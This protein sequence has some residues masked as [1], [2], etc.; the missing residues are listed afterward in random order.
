MG[1][2]R[3]AV[4][5]P[6][7]AL[8]LLGVIVVWLLPD[9]APV[10]GFAGLTIGTAVV[11]VLLYTRSSPLAERE[12]TAWR[13]VGLG[14]ALF[15]VGVGVVGVLTE[16]GITLP[17][18]GPIDA[19]FLGAYAAIIGGLYRLIRLEAG[20]REW[21]LTIVDALVAAIALAALV[22]DAF[23]H[24]LIK[25]FGEARWWEAAIA[26]TYPVM[27][28]AVVVGLM[29]LVMRRSAYHFDLRL[30][31]FALGGVAQVLAD[32]IFLNR[33]VGE[34]FTP[35]EPAWAVNL[36]AL[37]FMTGTAAIVD[38]VPRKR[39]FPEAPTPVWAL[40]WPYLLAVSLVI[41]HFRN[42]R[43]L[44]PDVDSVVL[45]DAVILIGVVIL[46]RQLYM[47]YRDRHRVD[48]KRAELVASVSH[49]LRTPLTAM[50]GFLAI[51]EQHPDEFPPEAQQE[52]IAESADQARHMS[53]LV[54]D[55]LMLAGGE[56]RRMALELN[57]VWAMAVVN[58]V[59]H[60]TDTGAMVVDKDLD[61]EVR[62]RLDPDRVRQA[63]S[64]LVTNALRYG[65]NR[66]LIVARVDGEDL[67]LEVHD[68][69]EG[70]PTRF[71]S[72]IWEHF[73]RGAHRLDSTTPGLGIGLSIVR[74]VA[75]SHGGK[76]GYRRSERL[77]GACF[78][79]T[80]PGCVTSEPSV[81]VTVG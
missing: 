45:L 28:I 81:P 54:A 80:I 20:G 31:L 15:G 59:I 71:E 50:V 5:G 30:V 43:A 68:D 58:S 3:W 73:E 14:V 25:T 49:E 2:M 61:A 36:I 41:V 78:T 51:L 44:G 19:F 27:D 4:P 60:Q 75:E 64:N 7:I 21:V 70:V 79:I 1:R 53:R 26:S 65:R 77:G 62:V 10:V 23:L 46:L 55:L 9:A 37:A 12:R 17:A 22:W 6:L 38:R 74:A 42:Y 35:A 18:F 57:D 13:L 76:A 52:M 29:I 63:L 39:E 47:I 48:E 8:L 72:L 24:E 67:L 11:A 16:S 56:Q 40:I 69:G 34:Q 66:C 33:S 32:F